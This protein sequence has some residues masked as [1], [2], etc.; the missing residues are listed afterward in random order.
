MIC[1]TVIFPQQVV[2]SLLEICLKL[3]H[4]LEPETAPPRISQS[5]SSARAQEFRRQPQSVRIIV[6]ESLLACASDIQ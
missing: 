1:K 3:P 6:P 4:A 2:L 5:I